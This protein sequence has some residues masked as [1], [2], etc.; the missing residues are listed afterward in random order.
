V[1]LAEVIER[2][3]LYVMLL[4]GPNFVVETL[5]AHYARWLKEQEVRGRPL[6]EV[7]ELFWEDDLPMVDLVNEVYQQD[8]IRTTPKIRTPLPRVPSE[9]RERYLAYALVPSHDASGKVSGVIIYARDEAEQ[10]A[11]EV[12]VNHLNA[13]L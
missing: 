8:T 2:A 7:T 6:K 1:H 10:R 11:K 3:P 12:E 13:P 9:S 5:N 4:R